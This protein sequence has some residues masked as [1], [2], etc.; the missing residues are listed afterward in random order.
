L[1]AGVC[2]ETA[3]LYEKR[4]ARYSLGLA[5]KSGETRLSRP[6]RSIQ[7]IPC[8][9]KPILSPS[10]IHLGSPPASLPL[11][12]CNSLCS[13]SSFAMDGSMSNM[14]STGSVCWARI[15]CM[16]SRSTKP[17]EVSAKLLDVGVTKVSWAGRRAM[18]G[19]PTAETNAIR[20]RENLI[21]GV[22]MTL[23]VRGCIEAQQYMRPKRGLN[24]NSGL[25]HSRHWNEHVVH[26]ASPCAS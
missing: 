14:A 12:S 15:A 11:N 13:A 26:K 7:S 5:S 24:W 19:T 8:R 17:L 6:V 22:A 23:G 20:A 4:A 18:A 16:R 2:A 25:G 9:R 21:T 3:L 1:S 10:V